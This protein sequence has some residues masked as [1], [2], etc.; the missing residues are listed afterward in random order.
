MTII[1]LFPIRASSQQNTQISDYVFL[2]DTSGSMVGLPDGSGNVVIFPEVKSTINAYLQKNIEP[3]ANVFIYP[4]DAGVH[5]PKMFKIEK[6][7]D[8][9]NIQDY[10]TNLRAEGNETWIYRSLAKTIGEMKEFREKHPNEK[11]IVKIF[12]YTDGKDTERNGPHTM[13]SVMKDYSLKRGEHDWWLYLCT[14]GSEFS[15]EDKKAVS[16]TKRAKTVRTDRGEGAP[17]FIENKFSTIDF[18]NLWEKGSVKRTVLL[19]LPDKDKMPQ[20]LMFKATAKFP[21]LSSQSL[22]VQVSPSKKFK[23]MARVNL[24]I[25][26]INFDHNEPKCKGL[27]EFKIELTTNKPFVSIVPDTINAKFLY[28]PPKTAA[29][30]LPDG[31]EYPINFG[32]LNIYEESDVVSIEKLLLRYNNEAREKGGILKIYYD[33]SPEN[34]SLLTGD[35]LT[36]NDEKNEYVTVSPKK[37]EVVFKVVANK[38]LKPGEYKG[39]LYIESADITITGKG[40]ENKQDAP[41]IKSVNWSFEIPSKPLPPWIWVLILLGI[42]AGAFFAIRNKFKPPVISDLKLDVRKPES[43]EID[44]AG[45]TEIKLGKDGEYF[46]DAQTSFTI[47]A[48]KDGVRIFAVLDEVTG[49]EVS[50]KKA[51]EPKENRIIGEERLFDGDIITFGNYTITVTSFSL[52]RE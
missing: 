16:N 2:L 28:N 22:G 8:V 14:L 13:K 37:K 30:S 38:D 21:E 11:H 29:I 46:Q 4:Y 6:K 5:D 31:K 3:P 7:S 1:L 49:G 24:E 45:R 9:A 15:D 36:I 43:N 44:L 25:T 39:K 33:L 10:I 18:G 34:P 32:E 42:V 52:I 20:D 17:L 27:H 26:L 23:P 12:L 50:L 51:D 35:N 40:L 47:R 41:N 19:G 48:V